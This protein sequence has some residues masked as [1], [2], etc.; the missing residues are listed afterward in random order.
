M[1]YYHSLLAFDELWRD[2][3]R[4]GAEIFIISQENFDK[5][6]EENKL[7]PYVIFFNEQYK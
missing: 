7:E 4:Q 5:L 1:E 3:N 2:V 6:K